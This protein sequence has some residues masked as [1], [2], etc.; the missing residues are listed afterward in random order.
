MDDE[1][2]LI[3]DGDGLAV[4]GR[5]AAVERFLASEGL[6]SLSRD[7]GL[8]RLGPLLRRGAGV[9]QAG[10]G[11]AACA[12]RWV[13]LT[14]ESARLVK[15]HGLM[16][17]GTPGVSYAMVGQPGVIKSWLQV[18]KG[19]GSFLTNPAVLSGAAGIMAQLARQHEMNEIKSRLA[20]IDKKVDDVLRG[21]K[22]AEVARVVGAG[23]DIDSAMTVRERTDRV[24][25][26]TWSTVQGRTHTITDAL[27]W[28]LLRLDA[29]AARVEGATG[30]IGDL[31]RTAEQA[32]SDVRELLVV[33]A[34]CLGL[35][36]ALDV[37]RLDRVL[38]ESPD[39]LDGHRLAL[40]ADRRKWRERIS[41]ET[42]HLMARMEAAADAADSH[43]LL[44][45]T[46]SRA[47]VGSV[48]RVALAVDD[49]H[50]S[51]GL[52]HERQAWEAT[53]WWD[54]A[55]D[56]GQLKN[57]AAEVGRS[58]LVRAGVAGL[59]VGAAVLLKAKK[60]G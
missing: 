21:Q 1:I 27:G 22:Y 12:G 58:P 35:Q 46:T 14:E 26:I 55:R 9:A 28:T 18:A 5:P 57:A 56:P 24:D 45:A 4:I 23:F 52:D 54:A 15:E 29:V 25:A 13:K 39:D 31:A 30:K 47:V 2:Q 48:N 41:R 53:R 40:S 37:L 19:P 33:L 32:A 51:L 43:V 11:I 8:P 42:G 36:D 3:G 16:D 60:T 59:G 38:D 7:F 6:L 44:H 34:H 49:F 50:R 20:T 17:S 10:S